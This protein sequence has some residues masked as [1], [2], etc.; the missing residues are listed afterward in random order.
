MNDTL[1]GL[2]HHKEAIEK[3]I[4][5]LKKQ[6]NVLEETGNLSSLRTD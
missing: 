3:D 2:S 4:A 1:K 6:I 5:A